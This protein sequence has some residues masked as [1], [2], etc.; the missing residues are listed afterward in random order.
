[1]NTT[2]T[3]V[4]NDR[5]IPIR[6]ATYRDVLDAPEHQV[7]EIVD[8][9]LHTHPRPTIP[10]SQASSMLGVR[11]GQFFGLDADG[12]GGWRILDEPELHFGADILVPDLAGWRWARMPVCPESAYIT[13]VPDWVSEVLSPKT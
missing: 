2:G 5:T 9:I 7:A 1:M 4:L 10:H 6:R 11:I 8:G 13:L 12:P 3:A